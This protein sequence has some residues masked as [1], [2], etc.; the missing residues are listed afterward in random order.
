M[1]TTMPTPD[2]IR[3]L[4]LLQRV[5]VPRE[6]EDLNGHVNVKHH[7]GMYDM[8]TVAVL[9]LLG[10]D[11]DWVRVERTGIFDLEHHIWFVN[12]VHVGEEVAL[13][14]RFTER[15]LKRVAG[16]VFLL[17]ESRTC[18]ASVIEFVSAAAHLD[19]RRAVPLPQV[20]AGRLDDLL[21]EHTQLPWPAP[22]S[23]AIAV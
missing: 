20:I 17:N 2:Q 13:H 16:L 1:R 3:S 10:I 11:E 7:L 6:W 12:E 9:E 5:T 19:A 15:N 18:L 14:I 8:T 22:R 21:T 23:G 4:P